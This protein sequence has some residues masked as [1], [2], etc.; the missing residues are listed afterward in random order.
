MNMRK[1]HV[2]FTQVYTKKHKRDAQT[3]SLSIPPPLSSL[4]LSVV[5]A[6]FIGTCFPQV[7]YLIKSLLR[8]M[9]SG[10]NNLTLAL[11]RESPKTQEVH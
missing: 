2:I 10:M 4:A 5:S 6:L 9:L 1:V 3:L 7:V 8:N 11:D